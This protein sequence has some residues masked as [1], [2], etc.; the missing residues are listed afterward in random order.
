MPAAIEGALEN[1]SA[2]VAAKIVDFYYSNYQLSVNP[3]V[4]SNKEPI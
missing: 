3:Q 2:S 1:A 4:F